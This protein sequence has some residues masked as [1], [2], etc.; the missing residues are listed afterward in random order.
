M[1]ENVV[2]GQGETVPEIRPGE[3]RDSGG[4][5]GPRIRMDEAPGPRLEGYTGGQVVLGQEE[6]SKRAIPVVQ[7]QYKLVKVRDYSRGSLRTAILRAGNLEEL[8]QIRALVVELMTDPERTDRP[9]MGTLRKLEKA[10][11]AKYEE[12]QGQIV[13]APGRQGIL[14]PDMSGGSPRTGGGI[15]LP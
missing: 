2:A 11:K 1:E 15:I 10:G 9:S 14:L 4:E 7:P 6:A 8:E 5:A 13:Q 12:L 3:D